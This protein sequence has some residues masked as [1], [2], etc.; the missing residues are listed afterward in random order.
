MINVKTHAYVFDAYGTL[1][2]VHAA[3]ARHRAAA[4]PDADRFSDIWRTKQL[5]YSWTMTLAGQY[6]DFWTLTERALDY[7]FDRVGSV[8]RALRP[9]LL[10]A[11]RRLDAF[12]DARDTLA[13]LKA[14]G[15]RLA[16]L[17]NGSPSMLAAAV[18]ASGIGGLLDAVISVDA[19]RLYKPRPEVYALV[20]GRFGI[21]AESV[22][23]VSSNRW[24]VM[25]AAS[26]GFRPVW[27][28]R[29]RGPDE[30]PDH[31]PVRV[32]ADLSALPS[33]AL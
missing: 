27:I 11:Y 15:V 19:V 9:Q 13:A 10:D 24:D 33:L 32:V 3:I 29:A 28:N 5:E 31:A 30:Y 7:A 1:F 2:D 6:A 25:G 18:D 8:N 17:S 26:F 22:V 21:A 16:I 12:P 20:T 14:Q 4:D 23:F